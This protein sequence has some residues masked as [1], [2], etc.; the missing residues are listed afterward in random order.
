MSHQRVLVYG[1]KGALGS[2]L[3]QS[4]KSRGYWVLSVG[5]NEKA[6]AF[7][8][9]PKECSTIQDQEKHVLSEVARKLP[10]GGKLVGILCVAGGWAGGNA[11]KDTMVASADLMMRQ[12]VWPALIAARLAALHLAPTGLLQFTGAAA[13]VS[14]TPG[15]I[16]YGLAKAAVHQ[17][18]ASLAGTKSGLPSGAT[19]IALLPATLDTPM[20]RKWMPKA[21]VSGWTSLSWISDLLHSFVSNPESRPESGTLIKLE[22]ANGETTT[23]FSK[24]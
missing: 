1:G 4:F 9:V 11:S 18:T 24:I 21:D 5:D 7:V 17:L 12:S 3:V 10:E 23:V 13:A 19:V 6:D 20:N 22:T 14:G 2:A 15:M 8:S 16:G